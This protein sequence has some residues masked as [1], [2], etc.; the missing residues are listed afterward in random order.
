MNIF[1]KSLIMKVKV[2]TEKILGLLIMSLIATY[3][4]YCNMRKNMRAL[5][6]SVGDKILSN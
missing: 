2:S 5:H 4:Q 3:A 1:A 6:E